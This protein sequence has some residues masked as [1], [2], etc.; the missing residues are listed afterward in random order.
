MQANVDDR[1]V[2]PVGLCRG[3]QARAGV[4]DGHD[5]VMVRGEEPADPVGEQHMVFCDHHP[6][7]SSAFTVVGAPRMAGIAT[8]CLG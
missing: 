2:G 1:D 6:Y 4:D 3:D 5:L 8:V 7:G